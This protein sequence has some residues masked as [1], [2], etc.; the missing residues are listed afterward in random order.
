MRH[1]MAHLNDF[2]GEVLVGVAKVILRG[3][4][5]CIDCYWN[6]KH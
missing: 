1:K 2:A 6:N 5:L 4:R 3:D